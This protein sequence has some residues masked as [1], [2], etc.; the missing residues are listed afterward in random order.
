MGASQIRFTHYLLRSVPAF[1][2]RTILDAWQHMP[3]SVVRPERNQRQFL[4]GVLAR[5]EVSRDYAYNR[6]LFLRVAQGWYQFN[7]KLF[8]RNLSGGN[9]EWIPLFQA[10][11]LPLIYEFSNERREEPITWC[12]EKSGLKKPERLIPSGAMNILQPRRSN[13]VRQIGRVEPDYSA[14]NM[15]S[16]LQKLREKQR[17]IAQRQSELNE[18]KKPLAKKSAKEKKEAKP[19]PPAIPPNQLDMDF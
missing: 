4:S 13:P 7:P 17:I 14:A 9:E 18:Q 8:V 6:S 1:E 10:L 19:K 15:E 12:F 11:N 5:N 3:K 2:T 16:L